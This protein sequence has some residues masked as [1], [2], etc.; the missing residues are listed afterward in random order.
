MTTYTW[1]V[2]RGWQHRAACADQD[3]DLFFPETKTAQRRAEEICATCPVKPDCL[4]AGLIN[5]ERFGIWAG[6]TL[7][8]RQALVRRMAS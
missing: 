8:E 7:T 3:P 4:A 2:Q 1:Q 5:D 6:L